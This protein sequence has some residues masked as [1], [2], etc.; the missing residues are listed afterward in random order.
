[1]DNC[2]NGSW[3]D[4][5]GKSHKFFSCE[6]SKGLYYPVKNLTLDARVPIPSVTHDNRKHY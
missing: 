5:N 6:D 4:Q 2:S 1:M 3:D